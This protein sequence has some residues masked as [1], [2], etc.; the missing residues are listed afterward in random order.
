MADEII[1]SI[2][3]EEE[4]RWSEHRDG[5]FPNYSIWLDGSCLDPT[6]HDYEPGGPYSNFNH[7]AGVDG[8][9]TD[10]TAAQ[11]KDF[12]KAKKLRRYRPDHHDLKVILRHNRS[13][14]QDGMLADYLFRRYYLFERQRTPA[15]LAEFV[16]MEN[17]KDKT[18]GSYNYDPFAVRNMRQYWVYEPYSLARKKGWL[19][20]MD[21]KD[22][23]DMMKEVHWRL[24][25]LLGLPDQTVGR[26]KTIPPDI[27]Y[28]VLDQGDGWIMISDAGMEAR[29]WLFRHK[30]DHP[31]LNKL[32]VIMMR[33]NGHEGMIISAAKAEDDVDWDLL[34]AAEELNRLE[35]KIC[36]PEKKSVLTADEYRTSDAFLQDSTSGLWLPKQEREEQLTK[37]CSLTDPAKWPPGAEPVITDNNLWG[38]RNNVIGSPYISGTFLTTFFGW[39]LI[40]DVLLKYKGP[41]FEEDLKE[42]EHLPYDIPESSSPPC[43]SLY[44]D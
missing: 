11:V 43:R 39:Q 15:N 32:V 10:C 2:N 18:N 5:R 36:L 14:D 16:E 34:G 20:S 22:Y 41:R 42:L 29:G 35:S 37:G 31:D 25:E 40:R 3:L 21:A 23:M 28:K 8:T 24:D 1:S 7:H 9:I 27:D 12:I 30:K 6:A 44:P 19:E 17:H 38:G 33:Q 26:A 4:I 13:L